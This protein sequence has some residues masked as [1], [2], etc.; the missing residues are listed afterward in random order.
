MQQ[1]FSSA[2]KDSMKP[3][4]PTPATEGSPEWYANLQAIQ[5]LMGNVFVFLPQFPCLF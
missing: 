5:N 2:Q 1:K 4:T 3:P